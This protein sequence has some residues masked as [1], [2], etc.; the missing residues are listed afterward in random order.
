MVPVRLFLV[1]LAKTS[2]L[3]H[4]YGAIVH[5]LIS[6]ARTTSFKHYLMKELNDPHTLARFQQGDQT[7][8]DQIFRQVE[9]KIYWKA[10]NI[11]KHT[12]EAEDVVSAVY[13]KF[14]D[15]KAEITGSAWAKGFLWLATRNACIDVLRKKKNDPVQLG[16]YE[17]LSEPSDHD[18]PDAQSR[19]ATEYALVKHAKT[20]LTERTVLSPR[21]R[22]VANGILLR[23]LSFEEI[24]VELGSSVSTVRTQWS[25]A[26]KR[27]EKG[28]R[29][30]F[31]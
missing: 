2:Y 13:E 3:L 20:L 19:E 5:V 14:W 30:L 12:A 22:E 18:E 8:F 1:H 6:V 17:H 15:K 10:L 23:G 29:G 4:R 31:G 24:A 11:V 28:L 27:L 16:G 21:M 26:R 25:E 9:D 7:V